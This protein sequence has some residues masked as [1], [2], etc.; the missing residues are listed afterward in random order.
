MRASQSVHGGKLFS[1]LTEAEHLFASGADAKLALSKLMRWEQE[2]MALQTAVDASKLPSFAN[3]PRDRRP[4]RGA[5]YFGDLGV[6]PG[7]T[8]SAASTA[9]TSPRAPAPAAAKQA[10]QGLATTT[11]RAALRDAISSPRSAGMGHLLALPRVPSK[12]VS[13]FA[14]RAE[15]PP[16]QQA[17]DG[18]GRQPAAG[19]MNEPPKSQAQAREGGTVITAQAQRSVSTHRGD[20]RGEGEKRRPPLRAGDPSLKLRT[21]NLDAL[22]ALEDH[23]KE[24]IV[25]E[26]VGASPHQMVMEEA[27]MAANAQQRQLTPLG[28][29]SSKGR[30]KAQA[31]VAQA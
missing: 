26:R 19:G 9:L 5:K 1:S 7:G 29:G 10:R 21:G 27:R 15:S 8:P 18:T 22:K 14:S 28:V 6:T 3:M 25:A 16:Q 23:V 13:M 4:S 31:E 17:G 11:V 2:M 24:M 20:E 30:A 12:L